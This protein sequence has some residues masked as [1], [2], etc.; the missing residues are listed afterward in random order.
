[1]DRHS[2]IT[3]FRN[4]LIF[5]VCL[6][7]FDNACY[8]I[9]YPF[10]DKMNHLGKIKEDTSIAII[11]SSNVLWDLDTEQISRSTALKVNMFSIAGGTME[12]RY[13][14]LKDFLKLQEKNP[15]SIV[16]L[17]TDRFAFNR[18]RYGDEAYK[19]LQGYY[20]SG[21]L[22]E[23]LDKKW[24]DS[25]DSKLKK[26]S[27][28]YSLNSEAYF[29]LSKMMDKIPISLASQF[30]L[31]S[32]L[33]ADEIEKNPIKQMEIGQIPSKKQ[34]WREHYG[35]PEEFLDYDESFQKHYEMCI[36]IMKEHPP[37][38]F[39]LLDTPMI[40]LFEDKYFDPIRNI[41]KAS[42]S[43]NIKYIN[44]ENDRFSN[45]ES[46]YFDA[47]HLNIIGRSIYTEE[48]IKNLKQINLLQAGGDSK[49]KQ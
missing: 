15:P 36:A 26:I 16:V 11:G 45:D 25:F 44:I 42:Q 10:F 18:K 30:V 5:I 17:H 24:D 35:D 20:H 7:I 37:I 43:E 27:K 41:L 4:L 22:K 46:L 12:F 29:I 3:N 2:F 19:S 34:E 38:T 40:Q 9:G 33:Y 28:A 49:N 23:Y 39:I 48:F 14:L 47:S 13:Y 8:K 31:Q 32:H 6:I 1:M 21:I